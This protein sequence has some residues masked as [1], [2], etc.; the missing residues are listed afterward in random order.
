MG[1]KDEVTWDLFINLTCHIE[2]NKRHCHFLK[3][4]CDIGDPLHH[5]PL[6]GPADAPTARSASGG[7][8]S[9]RASP[10][11]PYANPQLFTVIHCTSADAA[12]CL[13]L[14]HHHHYSPSQS[15]LPVV[16]LAAVQ[17]DLTVSRSPSPRRLSMSTPAGGRGEGPLTAATDGLCAGLQE[18]LAA[19]QEEE[20]QGEEVED[21]EKDRR[22]SDRRAVRTGHD[23]HHLHHRCT[24]P[25]H[26]HH[27]YNYR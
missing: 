24:S 22:W 1:A 4:T 13:L 6:D 15:V 11:A 27:Y 7:G 21:E 9:V 2:G 12:C 20:E 5:G 18:D 8:C 19:A 23:T 17:W 25:H 26:R 3:S 14:P 16:A 10:A